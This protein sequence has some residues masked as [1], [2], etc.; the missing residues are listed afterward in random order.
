[1]RRR[2]DTRWNIPA[3]GSAAP[4]LAARRGP[5][6]TFQA[7]LF[8]LAHDFGPEVWELGRRLVPAVLTV[9]D[10]REAAG[11]VREAFDTA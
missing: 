7:E 5:R 11:I 2:K 4:S 8:I 3:Q 1:M 10:A 9:E 6:R